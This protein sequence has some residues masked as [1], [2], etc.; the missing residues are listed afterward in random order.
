MTNK[1]EPKYKWKVLNKK[2]EITEKDILSYY[3][4]NSEK[5]LQEYLWKTY[6]QEKHSWKLLPWMNEFLEEIK[7]IKEQKLNILI[8]WDYDVDWITGAT[9]LQKWFEYYGIPKTRIDVIL[10]DR[11]IGYS[12]QKKYIDNYLTNPN[13][14][15]QKIDYIITVDC[16]INSS[17]EIE[18]I[19]NEYWIEIW[20]SDHHHID[21]IF[22]DKTKFIVH[23]QMKWSKYPFKQISWSMVAL[24]MIEWI[25][26]KYWFSKGEVEQYYIDD[27]E[28]KGLRENWYTMEELED[29]AM[30]WTIGDVMPI[31]DENFFLVRDSLKRLRNSKNQWIRTMIKYLTK[32]DEEYNTD[33]IWFVIAPRINAVWRIWDALDWF[34]LLTTHNKKVAINQFQIMDNTNNERKKLVKTILDKVEEI[35]YSNDNIIIVYETINWEE[36]PDWVIWLIAWRIKEKWQKPTICFTR[37]EHDWKVLYKGSW[38]SVSWFNILSLIEKINKKDKSIFS[39]FG[40]HPMAFWCSILWDD[41]FEDFKRMLLKE[42][43]KYEKET[44]VCLWTPNLSI[45]KDINVLNVTTKLYP[46]WNGRE[47]PKYLF[48]GKVV[49]VEFK[50]DKHTFLS[51]SWTFWVVTVIWWNNTFDKKIEVWDEIEIYCEMKPNYFNWLRWQFF[52]LD[53]LVK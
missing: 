28:I 52:W 42:D 32:D 35:D 23:A 47:S 49:N 44:K 24:K 25:Y 3:W 51:V 46:F 39:W 8:F 15:L 19:I 41:K 4:L 40:W 45:A 10:P 37:K 6:Q 43:I 29:I 50:N 7:K 20:V 17:K 5:D 12:I 31:I 2:G 38:R 1:I 36:I 9:I 22:C 34:K 53:L 16:W 11:E 18:K 30:L 48:K 26:E 21:W 13:R 27:D 14:K 33:F